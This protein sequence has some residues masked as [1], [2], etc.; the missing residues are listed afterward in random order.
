MYIQTYSYNQHECTSP[1]IIHTL[2]TLSIC[3]SPG[4]RQSVQTGFTLFAFGYTGVS[5]LLTW[6]LLPCPMLPELK[7]FP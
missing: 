5:T 1:I 2:L 7:N 4:V 6:N 3:D